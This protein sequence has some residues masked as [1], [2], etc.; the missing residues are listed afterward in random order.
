MAHRGNPATSPLSAALTLV[1]WMEAEGRWPMFRDCHNARGLKSPHFYYRVFDVSCLSQAVRRA[2][3]LASGIAYGGV[4]FC[5]TTVT[6]R[7]REKAC[8]GECGRTILDEGAHIRF[9]QHCRDLWKQRQ[10]D[11]GPDYLPDPA[12]THTSLKK[13]GVHVGGWEDLIDWSGLYA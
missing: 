3:D 5:E 8:L 9:C 4:S 12:F 10:E 13:I 7:P 1:G 11:N 6:K 2:L